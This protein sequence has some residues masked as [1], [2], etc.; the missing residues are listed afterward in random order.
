[1]DHEDTSI[2][3]YALLAS[4]SASFITPFMGSAINLAIPSIGR[5]LNGSAVMLSWVVSSFLLATAALL[6]PLGRLADIYGRKRMFLLGILIF[7]LFSLLCGFAWSILSLI[8]LRV[9]Q[10]VG[11]SLIFGTSIAILT[12]VYPPQ[13]RG[14][15]LGINVASVYIGLSVG[16][17]LGGILNHQLGWPSIFFFSAF[18]GLV[19]FVFAVVKLKGEWADARG[20]SF[21][22]PGAAAYLS[23][24][25]ATLFGFSMIASGF[26]KYVFGAGLVLLAIF[27]WRQAKI[28]HPLLDIRLF[29]RNLTF[30]F[31][32]LAA[33]INYSATFALG[34]LLSVYLQII[35]GFDSQV[36]GL[37][38][39][40]QPVLMASLSPL[41][42]RLSDRIDPRLVSSWGMGLT[43]LGLLAFVFIGAA[44][45]IWEI[46]LLLVV[47]GVGFA[48]F[49]SPNTNAIMGSVEKR[50]YG[51]AS[52]TL[53]TMRM[54][55]QATS[56][57][58]ATLVIHVYLGDVKLDLA[59]H[60][61]LEKSL[62]ISFAIFALTCFAGVFASLARGRKSE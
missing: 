56:M 15:V 16:P 48:L 30:A 34:F 40:S 52:S 46:V 39:L 51:V 43:S 27:V 42:G 20:E 62:S 10:A 22:A 8:I 44:M 33:L 1:M 60:Q 41:A 25:A 54:L 19:T 49:S 2:K 61:A 26:A 12:S 45:A 5:S 11:G 23:G 59:S 29:S 37:I 35:R 50:F 53:A 6:L 4:I 55:G 47:I 18:L 7:S 32:N 13:E 28:R 17:V 36:S 57:A 9:F 24:I 21:D 38:L 31:S 3:R 58:V 14:R